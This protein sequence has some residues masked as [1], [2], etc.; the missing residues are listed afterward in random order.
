VGVFGR[1]VDLTIGAHQLALVLGVGGCPA[2]L[3]SPALSPIY[4]LRPPEHGSVVSKVRENDELDLGLQKTYVFF[5]SV[6]FC[7]GFYVF[8]GLG[9][10]ELRAEGEKNQK[11]A[12]AAPGTRSYAPPAPLR[13][14]SGLAPQVSRP[15]CR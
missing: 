15:A 13:P 12:R 2:K 5:I 10:L 9:I 14:L 6:G 3:R 4:N 7:L 1:F 11:N 8:F